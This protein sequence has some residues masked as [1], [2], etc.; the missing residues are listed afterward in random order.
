MISLG[1]N[2]LNLYELQETRAPLP[3]SL[4]Y[5][6]PIPRGKH[7]FVSRRRRTKT[8]RR[9]P[10]IVACYCGL[11]L[12]VCKCK[13]GLL[14]PNL[15]IRT[16]FWRRNNLELSY[17]RGLKD[18]DN[19]AYHHPNPVISPSYRKFV[20]RFLPDHESNCSCVTGLTAKNANKL[21]LPP[22][23]DSPRHFCITHFMLHSCSTTPQVMETRDNETDSRF[24]PLG[25]LAV[26]AFIASSA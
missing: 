9:S 15:L 17:L 25:K 22:R 8:Q 14:L 23:C 18:T 3:S 19:N 2:P 10:Y 21:I 5:F 7:Y 12:N 16:A 1:E 6:L 11:V 24:L 26:F 4:S 13:L 20:V